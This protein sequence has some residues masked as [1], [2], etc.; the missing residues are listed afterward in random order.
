VEACLRRVGGAI[1]VALDHM[2]AVEA[3]TSSPADEDGGGRSPYSPP[4]ILS[5]GW[6]REAEKRTSFQFFRGVLLNR[7][8]AVG[9]PNEFD[10]FS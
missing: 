1:L 8:F 2:E 6:R 3:L 9:L 4:S 7:A 5:K 10:P